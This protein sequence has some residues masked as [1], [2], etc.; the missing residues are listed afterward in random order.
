MLRAS[1]PNVPVTLT[2]RHEDLQRVGF[3]LDRMFAAGHWAQ[4]ENSHV[5]PRHSES[6]SGR[7]LDL[8][9]A[10]S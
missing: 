1:E 6:L 4:I 9:D 5:C 2:V 8:L 10:S 3:K 7:E